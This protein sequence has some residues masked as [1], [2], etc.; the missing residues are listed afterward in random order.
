MNLATAIQNVKNNF[1]GRLLGPYQP[2]RVKWMLERELSNK[3]P[4]GILAD[5]MGLGKTIM[6]IATMLGNP[7]TRMYL[8]ITNFLVVC[9]MSLIEFSNTCN[10]YAKQSQKVNGISGKNKDIVP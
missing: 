10:N 8:L 5:E 3:A 1:R 2:A 4:G 6:T 7:Y 9:A